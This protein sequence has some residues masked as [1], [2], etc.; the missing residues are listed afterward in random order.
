MP[1]EVEITIRATDATTPGIASALAKF[2][3]LNAALGKVDFAKLNRGLDDSIAKA[4]A[5][6]TAMSSIG[7]GHIDVSAV[8]S[9]L[10]AI[11]AKMASL[12]LAD[13]VDI[14]IPPGRIVTQLNLLKRL[15]EQAGVTDL[16][17][18]NLNDAKLK[19]QLSKISLISETIPVRFDVGKIPNF[20][21]GGD[22]ESFL[23]KFIY[24]VDEAG[25]AA[26]EFAPIVVDVD[27]DL[28]HLSRSAAYASNYISAAGVAAASAAG[29]SGGGSNSGFLGLATAANV[30]AAAASRVGGGG[31]SGLSAA[32]AAAVAAGAAASAAAGSGGGSGSGGGGGSGFLGLAGA[33]GWAGSNF[34]KLTGHLSVVN[35]GF[36]STIGGIGLWH[37]ALDAALETLISV[38][39]AAAA[40]SVGIATMTPTFHNIS[41]QLQSV[42]TINKALGLQIPPL[43]GQFQSLQKSMAPQTIEVYGGALNLITG[44]TG[45]LS[46]VA[47]QVVGIFDTWTAK[48][49]IW[50]KGQDG[51]AK[52]MQSGIGFLQQF[53][54]ILGTLGET[55]ANLVKADPGTAHFLLD[56]IGGAAGVLKV[57]TQL[58]TPILLTAI[59]L[60]SM[61]VWGNVLGVALVRL[62]GYMLGL[63]KMSY[64]LAT[65]PWTW[66]VLLAAGFA[67][68]GYQATQADSATKDFI[69]NMN[70]QLASMT[71]SQALGQI[72]TDFANVKTQ[73]DNTNASTVYAQSNWHGLAR[74]FTSFGYDATAAFSDFNKGVDRIASGHIVSGWAAIGRAFQGIFVPGQGA[75]VQA[76]NDIQALDKQLFTLKGDQEK[77]FATEGYLVKQGFSVAQ[78][79]A[80]MDIAGVSTGDSIQVAEQKV[81]NL[82][83]GYKNLGFTGSD[84]INQM[85]AVTFSTMQQDSKVSS[86]NSGWDA[87]FTTVSGGITGLNTFKSGMLTLFSDMNTGQKVIDG[88]NQAQLTTQQQWLTNASAANTF[89][90]SL[91]MME[92]AAG[93]GAKGLKMLDQAQLDLVAVMLP[94]AKHSQDLTTI[95]Y[96]MAQRGGYKGA[97]SFKALSAWV[98]NTKDPMK[99]LDS[100]V[101]TLTTDSS[102]L[103]T[104]VKNL[105][106]AL[107]TTMSQAMSI[108]LFQAG[109]GQ[110]VFN[111]LATAI[112]DT[113]M[114]LT[115]AAPQ[116]TAMAISLFKLTGNVSDTNREFLTFVEKG[117]NLTKQQADIL[118]KET[119]PGLQG[120]IDQLHGKYIDIGVNAV[121]S[122]TITATENILGE[123][124][125]KV[126][127]LLFV[128][129]GGKI[130]GFGGGDS[131]LAMLE[132]GEA[133]IDKWRTKKYAPWL[134]MM[135]I[136]GF[137]MGGLIGELPAPENW[138]GGVE[139]Q[140]P[141]TAANS[142]AKSLLNVF[143]NDA[144]TSVQNSLSSGAPHGGGYPGQYAEMLYASS[145]FASHGWPGSMILPLG[146]LWTRESGWNPNAV[147]P[148]SGAYGIPQALPGVWGHP[149]PMGEFKPQVYWGENYI[150]GR[151]GNPANAWAHEMSYGWYDTGGWLKPGLNLMYNGLGRM[152]HLTPD[153]GNCT[154]LEIVGGG[155]SQVEEFLLW[156]IRHLVRTRGG[157]GSDSVQR[158]FGSR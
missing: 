125:K 128:S 36:L 113:R 139:K 57:I 49:N 85:N 26:R 31:N 109:G 137:S 114:S 15:A 99:N 84:L 148:T 10:E 30:A 131:Q 5:L 9:A 24:Q 52:I 61:Y 70:S 108:A 101:T 18:F 42:Y 59:A 40:A 50:A 132:P 55:L 16:L 153:G 11:K 119:L 142:G 133:V 45:I 65:S 17:D 43:T 79:F 29:N 6:S 89:M 80:L 14:N 146:A 47:H 53:G 126:G 106:T 144:A 7:I 83:T 104:D 71:A 44:R 92:S 78:S 155:Q 87:F 121:G 64:N 58:P 154:T 157:K 20:S 110:K 22:S 140:F 95:L 97:D 23:H 25:M 37:L 77:L 38:G 93:L 147:N 73:I 96:A 13:I 19:Q 82:I 28:L 124:Q 34:G 145:L 54:H 69:S 35:R 51:I 134:S 75:S 112:L 74:T 63:L 60:H 143:L 41:D 118:W 107:G 67:E 117:M 39:L 150:G 76:A 129:T 158:T 152:E 102:N 46:T 149:Y 62:I 103:I 33:A 91:T 138:M 3:L 105:S 48:I 135:G 98:G 116:A 86:L 151:Y 141:R 123:T 156:I 88:L 120:A 12:G 72:V 66:V 94:T 27:G 90:D 100:I 32:G 115:Q 2:K 130:P 81:E 127:S 68:A 1:N 4:A 111:N 21:F 56:I 136:P 122:G 8:G